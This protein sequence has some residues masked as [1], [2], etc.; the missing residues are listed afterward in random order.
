MIARQGKC[1]YSMIRESATQKEKGNE[2]HVGEEG[3]KED[4]EVENVILSVDEEAQL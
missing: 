2:A 3:K 4:A 1:T